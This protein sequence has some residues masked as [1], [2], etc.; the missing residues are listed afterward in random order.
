MKYS[1]FSQNLG[2]KARLKKLEPAGAPGDTMMIVELMD[3]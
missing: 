3:K 2:K 1:W